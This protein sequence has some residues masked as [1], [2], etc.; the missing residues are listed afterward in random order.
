MRRTALANFDAP[1]RH[2]DPA[3]HGYCPG[4]RYDIAPAFPAL[5]RRIANHRRQTPAP[6]SPPP[7]RPIPTP[8]S[9]AGHRA[10]LAPLTEPAHTPVMTDATA[11]HLPVPTCAACHRL[12][13]YQGLRGGAIVPLCATHFVRSPTTLRRAAATSLVV[14]TILTALNQ[15][16]LLLGGDANPSMWWKIPLTYLVP[17]LV[18]IW[19]ALTRAR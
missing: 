4:Y 2:F 3:R 18:T 17:F 11:A 6:E 8:P 14:G 1:P 7:R 9:P 10:A 5:A 15:G 12:A 13:R 19:G 16:D